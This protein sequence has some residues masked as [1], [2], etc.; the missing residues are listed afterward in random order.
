MI[1]L[2]ILLYGMKLDKKVGQLDLASK[3]E[4]KE[5]QFNKYDD[6]GIKNFSRYLDLTRN[7]H[8][9]ALINREKTSA[10][11]PTEHGAQ[12]AGEVNEDRNSVAPFKFEPFAEFEVNAHSSHLFTTLDNSKNAE[13]VDNYIQS[14]TNT[15]VFFPSK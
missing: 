6:E 15:N 9:S 8:G 5:S 3:I 2:N 12:R 7:I 10:C 1:D 4:I 13:D 11:K 14:Y